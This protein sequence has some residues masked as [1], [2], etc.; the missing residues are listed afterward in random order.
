[1]LFSTVFLLHTTLLFG[2]GQ[3]KADYGIN[4][5]DCKN[6]LYRTAR[7]IEE[8]HNSPLVNRAEEF[9][10]RIVAACYRNKI[11]KSAGLV[12]GSWDPDQDKP[13]QD[14]VQKP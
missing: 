1:M 8:D 9:S 13:D 5:S 2:Y 14:P 4:Q 3:L 12:G 7:L 10:E 6:E 11:S